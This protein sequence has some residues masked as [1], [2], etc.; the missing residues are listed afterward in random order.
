MLKHR[1]MRIVSLVLTLALLLPLNVSAADLSGAKDALRR[2]ANSGEASI[3]FSQYGI[4]ADELDQVY[5]DLYYDN[6]FPWYIESY[7]YT[8]NMD[9]GIIQTVNLNYKDEAIYNRAL[10][11]RTVQQILDETVFPGMSQWQIALSIHDYLVSHFCYDE[12]YTYYEG[13]DLL[14][15]GTAVCAG[16]ARAY[17]DLLKR[18]G[19]EA[20]Y[21]LSEEMDHGWNLVKINGNWYHVDCTWDDPISDVYGRVRHFYFLVDDGMI[22]DADHSHYNWVTSY[23]ATATDMNSNVFW[24]EL[25]SAICYESASVSYIRMD[26]KNEHWIYR[27]DEQT[28]ELTELAY[29]DAGYLDVGAGTY[30]YT[31]YGLSLWNGKLYFS[32]MEHVYSMNTDGSDRQTIYSYDAES[33]GRYIQGSFVDDGVIHLSL[34]NHDGESI[35]TEIAVPGYVPHEH[36]YTEQRTDPTCTQDGYVLHVCSCGDSYMGDTLSAT[37]HS[38]DNGTVTIQATASSEGMIT[39]TCYNC[40]NTYTEPIPPLEEDSSDTQEPSVT[41]PRIPTPPAEHTEPADGGIP[42]GAIAGVV[43]LVLIVLIFSRK[44]KPS[45]KP[46]KRRSSSTSDEFNPYG[47]RDPYG[48]STAA[49]PY[50]NTSTDPYGNSSADPYGNPYGSGDTDYSSNYET[51]DY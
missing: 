13:Y 39:Y 51:S 23:P 24:Q 47:S 18:S 19:I 4:N 34:A 43:V 30:H 10:Y 41:L 17:M 5:D 11:E 15:G 22:S 49:D 28:G 12:T 48:N 27:R 31:N 29:F 9:S 37:G 3:E 20:I 25:E 40:G 32:D 45:G 26:E 38:Y 42:T 36:S 44:K 16:Y 7:S 14:V 21:V 50:N 1:L 33:N 6:E 46:V 35:R 2:A 8:Y